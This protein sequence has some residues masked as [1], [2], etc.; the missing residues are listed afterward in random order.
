MQT[1]HDMDE[2]KTRVQCIGQDSRQNRYYSFCQMFDKDCRVYRL[3]AGSPRVIAR[4][5]FVPERWELLFDSVEGL[6][7]FI[8]HLKNCKGAAKTAERKLEVAAENIALLMDANEEKMAKE[9]E[10]E[11]KKALYDLMPRRRSNRVQEVS[12]VQAESLHAEA[13]ANEH[14]QEQANRQRQSQAM[15]ELKAKVHFS[16]PAFQNYPGLF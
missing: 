1:V 13:V 11:Q 9:R 15:R 7:R 3:A 8:A 5:G 16:E 2:L 4:G 14:A 6:R 12:D 10:K